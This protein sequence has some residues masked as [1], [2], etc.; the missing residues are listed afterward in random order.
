MAILPNP[1]EID[2][3]ATTYERAG[4][5]LGELASQHRHW[6]ER[7]SV[8]GPTA[9]RIR[10]TAIQHAAAG[11]RTAQNL[12][13]LCGDLRAK[14]RSIRAER[15][16]L[17]SLRRRIEHWAR[18]HPAGSEPGRDAGVITWWPPRH[19]EGWDAVARRVRAAGGVF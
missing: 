8:Q 16:R 12:F 6:F 7:C 19:D 4:Q 5:A 2:R 17:E 15:D 13:E 10:D 3:L 18:V 9:E 11:G 14:A 1:D